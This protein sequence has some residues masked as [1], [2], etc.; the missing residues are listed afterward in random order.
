M[1]ALIT[2]GWGFA[3]QHL[4]KHLVQC[5]DDVAVSYKPD[6]PKEDSLSLPSSTQ[7]FALDVT[8]RSAV[9]QLIPLLQPDAIYHLAGATFVPDAE[10]KFDEVSAVNVG[11][12]INLL[13]AVRKHAPS[14]RFLYV[15]SAEVY[16]EPRPG[17]LPLDEFAEMR[18]I[19]TYG[20]TKAMADVAVFKY[21]ARNGVHAVRARPFPH[22]GPGQSE[23]FAISSFAKQLSLIKL[24]RAE[25]VISVGNLE[26]RRDYSDV[27]DIVRGYREAL[28]NGNRGGAYNFC[29]G[30]SQEIGEVLNM[31]I[32][33]AEVEAEVVVDPERVR[34][35]DVSDMY[36]SFEKAQKAF[37]WKPRVELEAALH[38]VV[39]YWLEQLAGT[40]G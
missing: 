25:P 24:G 7:S 39:A 28:L 35:I 15:S 19:S 9:E 26:A 38:G 27:S 16:G 6:S 17:S 5:G 8:D 29:S 2:G 1:R 32:K 14:A 4:A 33:V 40:K 31:L 34:P 3:G 12:T 22:I 10:E 11:G 21:A 30:R 20:V 37:G 18:P 13:D 23:Q 36:G